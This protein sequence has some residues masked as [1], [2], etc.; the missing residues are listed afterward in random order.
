MDSPD[1]SY[2]RVVD[3]ST[4]EVVASYP[5]AHQEMPNT[6]VSMRFAGKWCDLTSVPQHKYTW[7]NQFRS[8]ILC[9]ICTACALTM[10]G[11][12]SSNHFWAN[13]IMWANLL[14]LVVI[15]SGT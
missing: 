6:I 1:A 5:L 7:L 15:I 8:N 11:L 3:D 14:M 10:V 4:F 12:L 2:F 9:C 13:E